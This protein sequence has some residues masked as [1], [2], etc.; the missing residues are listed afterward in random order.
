MCLCVRERS[1]CPSVCW[2]DYVHLFLY[3]YLCQF[4]FSTMNQRLSV[5]TVESI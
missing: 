1:V 3:L 2:T 4:K 5:P